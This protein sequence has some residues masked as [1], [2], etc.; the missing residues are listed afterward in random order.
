M[1]MILRG[2][3]L[4]L[5]ILGQGGFGTA[6]LARDF[7][8]P[9][10]RRCVAKLFQPPVTLKPAQM[11][12]AQRLFAKEAEILERIGEQHPQIPNLYAYFSLLITNPLTSQTEE[13]FYLVQEFIDGEDLEKILGRDGPFSE[14]AVMEVLTEMVKVLDFVQQKNVIHRDVKPSNIMKG[15]DGRLFLLDFGAVKEVTAPAGAPKGPTTIST[16]D[17]AP[18]EQIFG[19]TVNLTTDLY[20]L[21]A[22]CVVLLTNENPSKLR[23]SSTNSWQWHSQAQVS[24]ALAQ[25][26]DK[27]LAA[28]PGNRFPSAEAILSVLTSI[29]SGT[30]NARS[31]QSQS[32]QSQSNQSQSNQ[33]QS[34]QQ[35]QSNAQSNQQRQSNSQSNQRT[36][37]NA[38][39]MPLIPFLSGAAF[40]GSEGGLLAIAAFSLIET[41]AIG[42]GVWI[43]WIAALAVLG[44]LQIKRTIEGW[45]YLI[46]AGLTLAGVVLFGPLN[47]ALSGHV[48]YILLATVMAAGVA[49]AIAVLFRLIFTLV[50][51]FL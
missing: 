14:A 2:R 37:S 45:D 10:K 51:R 9:T 31:N 4:P 47:T 40:I 43:A 39:P 1:E 49:I 18:P 48:G 50:S 19:G 34:S 26:L 13:L 15:R 25:V 33:S 24:P 7:D 27:M 6:F 36:K 35:I 44:F 3:Y 21:A 46:I 11:A 12:T 5:S 8:S 20:A 22:S 32:N 29:Q 38:A 28:S 23:D 30:S 16:P 41:I 17:Y 42:G